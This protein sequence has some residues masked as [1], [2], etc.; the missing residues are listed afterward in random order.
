M[1]GGCGED[2]ITGGREA[3]VS[4]QA[5]PRGQQVLTWL[6]AAPEL[7]SPD[8]GALPALLAPGMQ[9]LNSPWSQWLFQEKHSLPEA[10]PPHDF[11]SLCLPLPLPG[12]C[13]L[14]QKSQRHSQPLGHH[15]APWGGRPAG[16]TLG[17]WAFRG[18]DLMGVTLP[19]PSMLVTRRQKKGVIN[20][21]SFL[22]V[23]FIER[24]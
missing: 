19:N 21:A 2:H 11:E 8:G 5:G 1:L 3:D 24:I 16:P 20:P 12:Q 18:Q 17:G 4:A 13:P 6:V 23:L 15:T 10:T 14:A 9:G 7:G 22:Q